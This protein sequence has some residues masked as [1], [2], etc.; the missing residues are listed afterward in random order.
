ME[1]QEM[2]V[3][4]RSNMDFNFNMI[5]FELCKEG[6]GKGEMIEISPQELSEFDP[7]MS[8]DMSGNA[9]PQYQYEYQDMSPN[10]EASSYF[11]GTQSPFSPESTD[12]SPPQ[13]L[14]K[15]ATNTQTTGRKK[16][17]RKKNLRPP[18]PTILKLRREAAN[19]RERKRMNGLN[20]AFERLREV[21][22][23][24]TAEQKMSK[25]ETLRMAQAYIKTLA[26]I[27]DSEQE[28]ETS[29]LP[30]HGGH[31]TESP[32]MYDLMWNHFYLMWQ[33]YKLWTLGYH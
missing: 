11:S 25:I 18:S 21:V 16:G 30:H 6:G 29:P 2:Y 14:N 15:P 26:G 33:K 1:Q 24:M 28:Q 3:D 7:N 9:Y 4:P 23:N 5:N 13:N 22:P 10:S 12:Y 20:D 31:E 27:M 8:Y 32:E 19:A 17:G